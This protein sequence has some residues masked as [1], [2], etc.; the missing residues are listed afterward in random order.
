VN[1]EKRGRKWLGGGGS[2]PVNRRGT[3]DPSTTRKKILREERSKT[4][5]YS[6]R[7]GRMEQTHFSIIQSHCPEKKKE[8]PWGGGKKESE[9]KREQQIRAELLESDGPMIGSGD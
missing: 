8:T 9:K 1:L 3:L 6:S 7:Y 2:S 5:S 4:N